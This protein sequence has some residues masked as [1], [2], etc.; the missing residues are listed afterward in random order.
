MS[1]R[2]KVSCLPGCTENVEKFGAQ[3]TNKTQ[4]LTDRTLHELYTPKTS[5]VGVSHAS[6]VFFKSSSHSMAVPDS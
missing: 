4:R 5:S 6:N 2:P 3:V 1:V